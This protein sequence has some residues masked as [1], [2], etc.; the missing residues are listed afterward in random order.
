[1]YWHSGALVF[2]SDTGVKL[3]SSEEGVHQGDPL[4][5]ALVA[6]GMHDSICRLQADHPEVVVLAYLDDVFILG[7]DS[8]ALNAFESLKSSFS[9]IHLVVTIEEVRNLFAFGSCDA[10]F[11]SSSL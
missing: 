8:S 6:L 4:G 11:S 7:E 3:L 9:G 2:A 1:M 10:I 5:P